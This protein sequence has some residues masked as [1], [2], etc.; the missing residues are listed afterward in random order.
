MGWEYNL[1][2]LEYL[3]KRLR[4]YKRL[5]T[6]YKNMLKT[7]LTVNRNRVNFITKPKDPYYNVASINRAIKRTDLFMKEFEKAI[8]Y[9][10]IK[11]HV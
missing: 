8:A 10:K 9:L 11:N 2:P 1:M 3:Q 4:Y 6:K 7:E 5:N